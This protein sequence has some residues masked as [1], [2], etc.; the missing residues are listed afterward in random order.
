MG[1]VA[2]VMKVIPPDHIGE[3]SILRSLQSSAKLRESWTR[4]SPQNRSRKQAQPQNPSEHCK[5]DQRMAK[6]RAPSL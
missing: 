2:A 6:A 5:V 3:L 1:K 4:R